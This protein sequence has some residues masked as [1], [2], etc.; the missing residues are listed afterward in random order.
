MST[1]INTPQSG[2]P[3]NEKT[4]ASSKISNGTIINVVLFLGLIILYTF[5]FFPGRTTEPSTK[6]Q[7]EVAVMADKI[8]EGAF[9]IA[10]VNSDSLMASYKLAIKM[11]EDFD[12][13][14]RRL[15]NDLQRRQRSFQNEVE[16][17]QRQI[18]TG[19][20][21]MENAQIREQ[22][23]M[24]QQQE[25]MQLNDTYANRLMG[26]EMEMNREL[27]EKI[28][29]LLERFNRELGY[30]YILGFTPGGGILHADASH[31]ITDLV[32]RKLNEEYDANR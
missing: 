11:R 21:T 12:Q 19:G 28:T 30:D 32:I 26:Q 1:E 13:E 15:E 3:G 8:S 24:Q 25:L 9:L 6:M 7:D 16:V 17:F 27:Y 23:L 22:E 14:Q 18:Q 10:F 5:N 2:Q 29:D 4:P 20:I 31:D